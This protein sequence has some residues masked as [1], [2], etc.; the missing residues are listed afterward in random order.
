MPAVDEHREL[1]AVGAP[2]V[3]QRVDRG[4]DRPPR[5]E[6]VVDEHA[7]PPFEREVELRAAH[8][9][10]RVERRRPA[11]DEHVVAVERDVDRAER[12]LDAAPLGDERSRSRCASGTPRVWIPTRAS[13][14]DVVVALDQLVREPG[15]RPRKGV[16]VED[17]ARRVARG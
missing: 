4:A 14:R 6:D 9:R 15:E 2:E 11:A 8:D 5:E 7:R 10:V 12:R 1:H 16:R 17:L 3:E 13:R